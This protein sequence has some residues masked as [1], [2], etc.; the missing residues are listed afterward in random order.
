MRDE[1]AQ[2]VGE[3]IAELSGNPLDLGVPAEK[4]ADAARD[5]R[6]PLH[7]YVYDCDEKT[8]ARRYY[9]ERARCLLRAVRTD[10]THPETGER[11]SVRQTEVIKHRYLLLTDILKDPEKRKELLLSA[12]IQLDAWVRKY[13]YLSEL[14][15]LRESIKDHLEKL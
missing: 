2:A 3:A 8:A 14:A 10:L 13:H 7:R 12:K 5:P 1:D 11:Y 15:A 6:S 9:V 4:V